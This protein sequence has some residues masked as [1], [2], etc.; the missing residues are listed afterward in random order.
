MLSPHRD[1]WREGLKWGPYQ[2][3]WEKPRKTACGSHWG[4]SLL[5][6]T[7]DR[8]GYRAPQIS[9]PHP[10]PF[11]HGASGL[12]PFSQGADNRGGLVWSR[13][14]ATARLRVSASAKHAWTSIRRR[15]TP[16]PT[17][18]G[19]SDG[20]KITNVSAIKGQTS[21]V[22]IRATLA[23]FKGTKSPT[24]G[25]FSS[26]SET[27]LKRAGF[28]CGSVSFPR[29]RDLCLSSRG[30]RDRRIEI[31]WLPCDKTRSN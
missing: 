25:F 11:L 24:L 22:P 2:V 7:H 29:R 18:C 23:F 8:A 13:H 30:F 19:M 10:H 16:L 6:H 20:R 27:C 21:A 31:W 9:L 1:V 17:W 4:P 28:W 15:R 14:P 26:S 5:Q 12:G 3:G